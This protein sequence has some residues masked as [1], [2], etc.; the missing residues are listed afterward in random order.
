MIVRGGCNW[1]FAGIVIKASAKVSLLLRFAR[2]S[3]ILC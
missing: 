3:S 2:M 1:A